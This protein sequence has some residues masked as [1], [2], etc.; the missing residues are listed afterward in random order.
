MP[1]S[2]KPTPLQRAG[3]SA[4]HAEVSVPDPSSKAET[5]LLSH[6]KPVGFFL[7]ENDPYGE[8]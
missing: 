6:L 4:N 1:V 7:P 5:L 3:E 8:I 2:C